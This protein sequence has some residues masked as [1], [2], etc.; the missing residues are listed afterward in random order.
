MEKAEATGISD[1][2]KVLLDVAVLHL[3]AI[4]VENGDRR[5]AEDTSAG[6]RLEAFDI[7]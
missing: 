4:G 6:G 7:P 1:G 3:A 5:A 2:E